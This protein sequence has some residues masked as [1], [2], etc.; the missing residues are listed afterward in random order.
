MDEWLACEFAPR[1]LTQTIHDLVGAQEA[2]KAPAPDFEVAKCKIAECDRKLAGYRAAL[3]SGA[4][5]A[6]VAGWLAETEA[7][8]ARHEL[9]MRQ[10]AAK[11]RMTEADIKGIVDRLADLAHVLAEADPDGKAEIFRQLG[12]KLTY[13]PGERLV[14]ATIQPASHWQIDGVRGGT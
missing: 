13:K 12:L 5:G 3:D 6:T 11:G 14:R 9:G 4:N 1:R 2:T 8:R 7:E 10:P